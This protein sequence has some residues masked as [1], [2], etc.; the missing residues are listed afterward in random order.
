MVVLPEGGSWRT[1]SILRK[2]GGTYL[3]QSRESW[4]ERRQWKTKSSD[5]P[6]ERVRESERLGLITGDT[7]DPKCI[8]FHIVKPRKVE[9]RSTS[10]EG[11]AVLHQAADERF[12]FLA[13]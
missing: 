9:G 13:D 12:K 4:P 3:R 5:L 8:C 10:P 11:R 2:Y 7:N 1:L 6:E